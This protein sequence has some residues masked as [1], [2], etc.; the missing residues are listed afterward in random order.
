MTIAGK[1][2]QCYHGDGMVGF[3]LEGRH[4]LV[5][6]ATLASELVDAVAPIDI[7]ISPAEA[8]TDVPPP[9]GCNGAQP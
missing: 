7:G 4:W 3:E 9:R 8:G 6:L 2:V 1:K 5:P